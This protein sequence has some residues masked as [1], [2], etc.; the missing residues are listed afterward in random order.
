MPELL[1]PATDSSASAS[2][3]HPSTAWQRHRRAAALVGGGVLGVLVIAIGAS[4]G[5]W[6][7]PFVAGLVIGLAARN[8]TL[9]SVLLT[10]AAIAVAGWAIPLAWQAAHGEPVVATARI[11]AAL[12]GLP[13]SAGLVLGVTV[14]V[15]VIQALTGVWVGRAIRGLAKA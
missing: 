7:L 5:I 10:A 6:F 1:S 15:A 2:A 4:A 3:G 12:A 11:A 13:A 8:R 9:R 14:L